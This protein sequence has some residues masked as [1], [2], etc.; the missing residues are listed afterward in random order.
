M[1]TT[2][3]CLEVLTTAELLNELVARRVLREVLWCDRHDIAWASH[4][5]LFLST[6]GCGKRLVWGDA[7]EAI[8]TRTPLRTVS[9]ESVE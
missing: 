4:T 9:Q 6:E 1:S 7:E 5:D 8:H 3:D 2:L